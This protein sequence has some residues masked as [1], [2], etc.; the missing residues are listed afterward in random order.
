MLWLRWLIIIF[1]EKKACWHQVA[2]FCGDTSPWSAWCRMLPMTILLFSLCPPPP[3]LTSLVS[4]PLPASNGTQKAADWPSSWLWN[5]NHFSS[6]QSGGLPGAGALGPWLGLWLWS[7]KNSRPAEGSLL[8][9]THPCASHWMSRN[10]L[11]LNAVVIIQLWA[12]AFWELRSDASPLEKNSFWRLQRNHSDWDYRSQVLFFRSFQ[13][14]LSIWLCASALS[15]H[16][17]V[18]LFLHGTVA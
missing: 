9:Q 4:I 18:V 5:P 7:P 17:D 10:P 2:H 6:L 8:P 15:W 14:L 1:E 16:Q 3:P 12:E 13:W 11:Q